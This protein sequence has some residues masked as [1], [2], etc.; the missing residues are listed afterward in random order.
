MAWTRTNLSFSLTGT[1][2]QTSQAGILG[3][4]VYQYIQVGAG[5]IQF[6]LEFSNDNASWE[7]GDSITLSGG[8]DKSYSVSVNSWRWWRI[9]IQ[10]NTASS[11]TLEVS[12][13]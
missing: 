12:G 3:N 8:G 5:A 1:G 2:P 4:T 7:I 9:N 13:G 11:L 6:T 10:S